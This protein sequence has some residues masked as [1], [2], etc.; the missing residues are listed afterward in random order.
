MKELSY[1][2]TS[3]QL[4]ETIKAYWMYILG[5]LLLITYGYFTKSKKTMKTFFKGG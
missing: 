2:E 5:L 1:L 3:P 4:T